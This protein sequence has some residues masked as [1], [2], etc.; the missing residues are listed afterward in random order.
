MSTADI[1]K[2]SELMG[3]RKPINEVGTCF[4]SSYLTFIHPTNSSIRQPGDRLCHGIG[5]ANMPGQEGNVMGHAWIEFDHQ[6]RRAAYDSIWG[7]TTSAEKYR[8]DLK[9][10]YVREYTFEDAVVLGHLHDYSGP[11]DDKIK[12]ITDKK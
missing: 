9:L 8:A 11:W 10:E 7:V 4:D 1:E 2:A 6:G 5:V 3:G 12:A